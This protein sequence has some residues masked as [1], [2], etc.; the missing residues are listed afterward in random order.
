LPKRKRDEKERFEN[1]SFLRSK[2]F[3]PSSSSA[4][5]LP[6]SEKQ[7]IFADGLF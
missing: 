7:K 1:G 6:E 3:F 2:L 5:V 4:G